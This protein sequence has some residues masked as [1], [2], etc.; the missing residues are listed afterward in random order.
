MDAETEAKLA[1]LRTQ[2]EEIEGRKL[3][4]SPEQLISL[5]FP[6]AS[7]TYLA[8]HQS[9]N[10]AWVTKR[11]FIFPIPI[12]TD[13]RLLDSSGLSATGTDGKL[14][15]RLRNFL[16]SRDGIAQ[17]D[18]PVNVLA[19]PQ[20][21]EPHYVT[22]AHQLIRDPDPNL[23]FF[24]DVEITASTWNPDGTP[25]PN[26]RFYWRCRVVADIIIL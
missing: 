17:F 9:D 11:R 18:E 20:G 6:I 8:I 26:I 5:V 4:V 12:C 22:V 2:L 3:D 23:P 1:K 15:F 21:Q 16:C 24:T 25:A 14:V 13:S 7:H 19:T 10:D